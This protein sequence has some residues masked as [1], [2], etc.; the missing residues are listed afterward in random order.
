MSFRFTVEIHINKLYVKILPRLNHTFYVR[1]GL[2]V[3]SCSGFTSR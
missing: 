1:Q 2:A 3:V